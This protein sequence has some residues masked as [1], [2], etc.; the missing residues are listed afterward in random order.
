MVSGS[1]QLN[2]FAR[3]MSEASGMR[4]E[5]DLI[6]YILTTN[7]VTCLIMLLL[8]MVSADETQF[9]SLHLMK[10]KQKQVKQKEY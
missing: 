9:G 7:D 4:S 2:I 6:V 1:R 3:M 10:I 5:P 8:S